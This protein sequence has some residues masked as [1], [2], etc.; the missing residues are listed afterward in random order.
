ML[1]D[2]KARRTGCVF[3]IT[4]AD[5]AIADVTD[6]ML[7]G[8]IDGFPNTYASKVGKTS[9]EMYKTLSSQFLARSV[10]DCSISLPIASY[11]FEAV[12]MAFTDFVCAFS[13]SAKVF[14]IVHEH[15]VLVHISTVHLA[16]IAR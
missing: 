1:Q 3:Q 5:V 7:D 6:S 13:S 10:L 2:C 11:M 16:S 8:I 4:M 15:A 12:C 14:L 9:D